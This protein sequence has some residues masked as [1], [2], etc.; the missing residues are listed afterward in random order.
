MSEMAKLDEPLYSGRGDELGSHHT[1]QV[2]R[3]EGVGDAVPW[4]CASGGLTG[5]VALSGS[6]ALGDPL[7]SFATVGA[8]LFSEGP[9]LSPGS[10]WQVSHFHFCCCHRCH[11]QGPTTKQDVV[12]CYSGCMVNKLCLHIWKC[13]MHFWRAG[14]D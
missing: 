1:M 14:D 5:Q 3:L 7:L 11:I 6:C 8:C 12:G 13:N 9:W 2:L 4:G 10:R